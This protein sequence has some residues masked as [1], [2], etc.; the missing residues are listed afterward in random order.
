MFTTW[1][2]GGLAC[3][4]RCSHAAL[5][6]ID[7]GACHSASSKH[8]ELVVTGEMVVRASLCHLVN[9]EGCDSVCQES[10][11]RFKLQCPAVLLCHFRQGTS[12]RRQPV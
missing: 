8:L 12:R 6:A 1:Y 9:L 10:F 3:A 2:L 4:V 5:I 7:G 11:L